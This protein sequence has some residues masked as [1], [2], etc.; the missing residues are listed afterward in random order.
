MTASRAV[1]LLLAVLMAGCAT[2]PGGR[3]L[4]PR[5]RMSSVGTHVVLRPGMRGGGSDVL[6][7]ARTAPWWSMLLYCP[8]GSD[9]LAVSS[10]SYD[11]CIDAD[12]IGANLGGPPTPVIGRVP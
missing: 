5:P 6:L 7:P 1:P 2:L 9:A 10:G 4:L 11:S 8:S 3:E 12:S